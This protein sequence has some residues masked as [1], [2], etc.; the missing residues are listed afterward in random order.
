MNQFM[1]RHKESKN[2]DSA[3]TFSN[4]INKTSMPIKTS[5]LFIMTTRITINESSSMSEYTLS[6]QRNQWKI[7]SQRIYLS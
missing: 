2:P 6:A 3:M 1:Q 4:R 5:K 7:I